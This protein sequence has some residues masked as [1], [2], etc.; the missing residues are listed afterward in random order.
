M[1]GD[2][3]LS[4]AGRIKRKR[5]LVEPPLSVFSQHG[6]ILSD[7]AGFGFVSVRL[8]RFAAD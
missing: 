4:F 6:V 3:D 5:R 8:S 1:T 2:T 7:S